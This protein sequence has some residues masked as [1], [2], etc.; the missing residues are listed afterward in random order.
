MSH[1]HRH[2]RHHHVPLHREFFLLLEWEGHENEVTVSFIGG[3]LMIQVSDNLLS[4]LGLALVDALGNPAN[5]AGVTTSWSID[6]SAVGSLVQS[7]DGMSAAFTP[8]TDLT[9][10]GNITVAVSVN[11][12][13]AFSATA[14]IQVVSSAPVSGTISLTGTAPLPA[15]APVTPAPVT[16]APGPAA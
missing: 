10:V 1:I 6:N 2:R 3:D 16:P 4:T 11:G 13:V 12:T 15:A 14:Q 7:T 5:L 9:D 8:G